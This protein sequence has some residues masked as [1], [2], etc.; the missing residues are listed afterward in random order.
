MIKPESLCWPVAYFVEKTTSPGGLSRQMHLIF[1]QPGMLGSELPPGIS[2]K[3]SISTFWR[4][5][6][7]WQWRLSP[8]VSC[9]VTPGLPWVS[10]LWD[11]ALAEQLLKFSTSS[12]LSYDFFLQG[13][14]DRRRKEMWECVC[15]LVLKCWKRGLWEHFLGYGN[16]MNEAFVENNCFSSI[17]ELVTGYSAAA[18]CC[19]YYDIFFI[20]LYFPFSL[21]LSLFSFPFSSFCFPFSPSFYFFLIKKHY[22]EAVV[23]EN[24]EG[25]ESSAYG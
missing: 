6:V 16:V 25:G 1:L 18:V 21:S 5:R 8:F 20:I 7:K 17:S 22:L 13:K 23:Q 3:K 2:P 10:H 11:S 24:Y 19:I 15:V 4:P 9:S 12:S 14:T